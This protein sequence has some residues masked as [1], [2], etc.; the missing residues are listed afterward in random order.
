[1]NISNEICR[2]DAVRLSGLIRTKQLSAVDVTRAVIDRMDRLDPQLHA[3]CTPTPE[4]AIEAAARVEK[5]IMSGVPVGPLAGG[6]R[7]GQ[8][9]RMHNKGIK[10]VSGSWAYADFVPDEDDVVVERLKAGGCD[11]HWQD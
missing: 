11:H 8:G 10:T 6:S 5:N 7:G 3:F 2:M 1:M 9:S 4:L